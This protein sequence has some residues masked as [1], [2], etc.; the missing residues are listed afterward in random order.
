MLENI[1][2]REFFLEMK[3][4]DF[5]YPMVEGIVYVGEWGGVGRSRWKWKV[6]QAHLA[7]LSWKGRSQIGT[8]I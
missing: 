7:S 8:L 5:P 3:S 1:S 2:C 4:S 6:A